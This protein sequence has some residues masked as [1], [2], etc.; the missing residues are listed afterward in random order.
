MSEALTTT[1]ELL[2]KTGNEAAVQVLTAALD[3]R[4]VA[5]QEGALRAILARRSAA[6]GRE[7]LRRLHTLPPQWQ[8]IV[9]ENHGRMTGP[10]RD[11]L[12]GTDRQMFAN[13]CRA[14]VWFREYDLTATL[15]NLLEDPRRQNADLAGETLLELAGVLYDELAAPPDYGNRRD[16]QLVREHVVSSIEDSV[17][18]FARHRRRESIEAFL[19]LAG[20]DHVTLRQILRDPHDARFLIV[21]EILSTSPRRGVMRLLLNLLDD[22]QAPSAALSVVAKRADPEFVEP[23]LRRIGQELSPTIA[24]NLRR[25]DSIAWLGSAETVL[26]PLDDAAQ[27]AAVRM[28]MASATPRLQVFSLIRHLMLRGTP[29]GRRAAAEALREFSGAEANDL[30]LAALDDPDPGV[31]A[32]AAAQLRHRGIPGSLTRLIGLIDSPHAV[33]RQAARESLGEFTFERFLR[34]FDMLED[35][36]ARRSTAMLVHKVD[37]QTIPSLR[38]EME[39]RGRIRRLRGLA[40]ARILG[41][42]KQLEPVVIELLQDEDHMVRAEAAAALAGCTSHAS[43]WAL[44]GALGDRSS[45]VKVA[46]GASLAEHASSSRPCQARTPRLAS[47]TVTVHGPSWGLVP[48]SADR[49]RLA[50]SAVAENTDRSPSFPACERLRNTSGDRNSITKIKAARTRR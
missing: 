31:Q 17:K 14:A 12:L 48:F 35:E 46:A 29:G 4:H 19:C 5:I 11:A 37:P 43:R 6:G 8:E 23:L 34:A 45:A 44:H 1:F 33:V 22:P 47:D 24:G 13:A 9:R 42:G 38:E 36:E 10:L 3:S 18:R 26:G 32:A 41:V 25:I 2:A 16:P 30:V 50:S 15:L 40:I 7:L 20:H 39:S 28:A 21:I 49:R 27:D